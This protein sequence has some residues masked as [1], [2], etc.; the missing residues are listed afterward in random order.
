MFKY[1]WLSIGDAYMFNFF[2][3]IAF[4]LFGWREVPSS[5]TSYVIATIVPTLV[6]I[7]LSKM[8]EKYPLFND[9]TPVWPLKKK[10]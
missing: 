4:M 8:N 9:S 2:V 5:F 1:T 6:F 10:E 7:F 3:G